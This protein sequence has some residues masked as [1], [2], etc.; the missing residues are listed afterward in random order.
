MSLPFSFAYLS[1]E[2]FVLPMASIISFPLFYHFPLSI[3]ETL[4]SDLHELQIIFNLNHF[5]TV[6]F[7]K[8]ISLSFMYNKMYLF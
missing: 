8:S 5:I 2:V 7:L 3:L 4:N 6:Q 1:D